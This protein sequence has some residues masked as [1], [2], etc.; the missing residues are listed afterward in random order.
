MTVRNYSSTAVATTLSSGIT[1]VATTCTVG[2]TTGFPSAPFIGRID[3]DTASEELVLVT[4][5]AGSVLTLTRGYDSTSAQAHSSGAAFRHSVAAIDLREPNAHV[6]ASSGVHGVTGSVVGTTDTQT[7]TNKTLSAPI[8]STISNTGTVTLPT[9]TD[10][11]VGRNTTDTLTNKTLT[12]PTV[13]AAALTGTVTNAGT[14]SGGTV[15]ATTL[16][17]GGVQVD[18]ISSTST[19]TNKTLT[20]PTINTPS[21]TDVTATASATGTKA[22]LVKSA[23]T[24]PTADIFNITDSA[25]TNYFRVYYS[26]GFQFTDV[27]GRFTASNGLYANGI[28]TTT[29]QSIV[30]GPTGQSVD[31]QQW[32]VNGTAVSKVDSAGRFINKIPSQFVALS[33]GSIV[34]SG[35]A[36]LTIV[37]LPSITGDGTSKVKISFTGWTITGTVSADKFDFK[38]M[39][40]A[41]QLA[42]FRYTVPSTTPNDPC[43]SGFVI[44]T[45]SAAAHTYTVTVTRV[46][47]TGTLTISNAATF[48]F[49]AVVEQ[50]LG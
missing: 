15:N 20:S 46:S 28:F 38:I 34:T 45:P 7:L 48:P 9:S 16:Q 40:G 32:Q 33:S 44:D 19:L 36:A 43:P 23:T 1:N 26:G 21:M 42:A 39:D 30:N 10:T 22:L 2:A 17:Q 25:A 4:N 50:L 8:I 12:N 27:N 14:I 3:A 29:V 18:T 49:T 6:N 13:N 37:T 41:T 47:G 31:L 24:T 35:T 5:V 11:L